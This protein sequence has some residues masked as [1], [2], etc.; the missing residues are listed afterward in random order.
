MNPKEGDY[1]V[2]DTGRSRQ[3]GPP[4][5]NAKGGRGYPPT[6]LPSGSIRTGIPKSRRPAV[7]NL[8]HKEPL[9]I[10]S[11]G[12][13]PA[14]SPPPWE[15]GSEEISGH[16]VGGYPPTPPSQIWYGSCF[17]H[18]DFRNFPETLDVKRLSGWLLNFDPR[19]PEPVWWGG[20]SPVPSPHPWE[21][22]SE[23]I[24]GHREGGYPP[25]LPVTRPA[26]RSLR[27]SDTS[28]M[29]CPNP[30]PYRAPIGG[31]FRSRRTN[32]PKRRTKSLKVRIFPS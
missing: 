25:L 1:V 15:G 22:G 13:S 32:S 27:R 3:G 29:T 24:S 19:R 14:P 28:S 2:L 17:P 16:M 30:G 18:R 8:S 5:P 10:R 31:F 4:S 23:E 26:P 6:P 21:G 11:G 9:A 12:G 7:V 20:G